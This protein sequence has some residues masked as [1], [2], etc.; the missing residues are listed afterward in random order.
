[1]YKTRPISPDEFAKEQN[2]LEEAQLVQK[3]IAVA[4][5][6]MIFAEPKFCKAFCKTKKPCESY[7]VRGECC[8]LSDFDVSCD[9]SLKIHFNTKK[10]KA[11]KTNK[12]E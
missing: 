11:S 8:A 3:T 5:E 6:Y 9:H 4:I 12:N 7:R 2:T 10:S 1:M